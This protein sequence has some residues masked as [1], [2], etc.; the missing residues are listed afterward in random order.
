MSLDL[1][2]VNA[3]LN[4][5]SNQDIVR[6]E[7]IVQADPELVTTSLHIAAV[8]GRNDAVERILAGDPEQI[9]LRAGSEGGEPLL[10]LGYSPFHGQSPERDEGLAACAR[11]LLDAGADPN[12]RDRHLG[13]SALYAVTGMHNVP[14]I[15]RMLLDAGANPNDGES[16]FHAAEHFHEEA[17]DLLLGYGA[18]VNG[19]G[20]GGNTPLYFLLRFH[21]VAREPRVKQG[22]LW[23]LDYGADPDVRSGDQRE[24]A[25]HV[26]VRRG[27]APE[28]LELLIEHAAD[29]N[30]RRHDGRSPWILA[31]RAGDEAVMELLVE[32]G[33]VPETLS[34]ADALAAACN[35][36]DL[37]AARALAVPEVLATLDP[38]DVGLLPEAAGERR[39]HVVT[40]CLAAGFPVNVTD[41]WGATALHHAAIQG[42]ADLACTLLR[43]GAD[44]TIRDHQHKSTP[45]GWAVFG[46]DH[47][48]E[49]DGDYAGVVQALLEAGARP[50]EDE[51]AVSDPQV[52]EILQ[53]HAM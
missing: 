49:T 15:A 23:L 4:A 46:A 30:A 35:R 9:R 25:L 33:A 13:V 44:F 27:Q 47:V 1:Q 11:A 29:V 24:T 31:A 37:Q 18:D 41:E 34:P 7:E 52:R 48:R 5:V 19:T 38:L 20:D 6:A 40:A 16:L 42:R 26:A 17:L 45:F 2:A 39:T 10:W 50:A 8:L 28:I 51:H 3:F 43:L 22:V 14:R 53:R 32:N 12:T 21:N 36:G